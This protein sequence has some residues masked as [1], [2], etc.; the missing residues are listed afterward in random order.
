[1][2]FSPTAHVLLLN[3]GVAISFGGWQQSLPAGA[4]AFLI[5][6]FVIALIVYAKKPH[7]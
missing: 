6:T 3:V 7:N 5:G 4:T 2:K 1:M